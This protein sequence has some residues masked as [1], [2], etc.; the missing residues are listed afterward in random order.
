[1]AMKHGGRG[2]GHLSRMSTLAMIPIPDLSLDFTTGTLDPL[3]TASGGTNGTR[4]NS[5][6]AIVAASCPRFD[7]DPSTL[8]PLGVWCEPERTNLFVNSLIDGTNLS[9]QGVTTT[10]QD[11]TIS[12]Y[13]S[14]SITLSGTATATINGTGAYPSRKVQ[15]VT[16]TAGTLTCTVSGTVQYAQ[17]EAGG[18]VTSFIPTAGAPVTRTAD[19][20]K[21]T[22]A[23]FSG[24]YNQ[25]EGT[26]VVHADCPVQNAGAPFHAIEVDING[27]GSGYWRLR[28]AHVF[29]IEAISWNGSAWVLIATFTSALATWKIAC[30]AAA[31]DWAASANGAAVQTSTGTAPS[32][33]SNLFIG[34]NAS[35]SQPLNGRIR[36][37]SYYT[38]RISNAD[39]VKLS[40]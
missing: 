17:I 13:G 11:Y 24:F 23:N 3:V 31:G 18:T 26:F 27:G 29:L 12:F 21:V 20:L 35:G 25:T 38:S 22:G 7:Y 8:A 6:G 36:S 30:A 37:I 28:R 10:A 2:P 32:S 34:R 14:G 19:D 40:S 9:T 39:L 33:A 15:T 1:M 5:S 4:I 16:A